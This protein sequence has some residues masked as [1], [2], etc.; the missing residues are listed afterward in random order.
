MNFQRVAM[1]N[2]SLRVDGQLAADMTEASI[3]RGVARLHVCLYK[4][5]EQLVTLDRNRP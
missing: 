1:F 2:S 5:T 4:A 3:V